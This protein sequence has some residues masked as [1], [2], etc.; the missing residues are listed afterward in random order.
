M[1]EGWMIQIKS[2]VWHNFFKANFTPHTICVALRLRTFASQ[3]KMIYIMKKKH[4]EFVL[5]EL[6]CLFLSLW[7]K[8]IQKIIF[9]LRKFFQKVSFHE[10]W[11]M[12]LYTLVNKNTVQNKIALHWLTDSKKNCF[13]LTDWLKKKKKNYYLDKRTQSTYAKAQPNV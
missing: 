11:T 12:N 2:C 5:Y 4:T 8:W 9:S 1:R 3:D 7:L 10:W 13:A 6:I